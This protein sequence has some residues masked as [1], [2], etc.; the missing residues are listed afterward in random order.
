MTPSM[1]TAMFR[2]ALNWSAI[3]KKKKKRAS[4]CDLIPVAD[5][6]EV[7]PTTPTSPHLSPSSLSKS[8]LLFFGLFKGVEFDLLNL[9]WN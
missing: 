5:S 2:A 3:E 1:F 6:E 9:F 4:G 8:C 7:H